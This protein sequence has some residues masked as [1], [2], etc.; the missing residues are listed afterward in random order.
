MNN[1]T[2]PLLVNPH[3]TSNQDLAEIVPTA[4][5]MYYMLA[6]AVAVCGALF[7]DTLR[8]KKYHRERL[9]ESHADFASRPFSS[10]RGWNP[11]WDDVIL[12]EQLLKES[13]TQTRLEMFPGLLYGYCATC[14]ELPVSVE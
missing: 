9:F 10:F 2:T 7:A 3:V 14:S 1:Y 6:A 11:R 5:I 4:E 12:L 13:G 8:Y